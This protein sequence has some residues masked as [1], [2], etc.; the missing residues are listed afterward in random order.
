MEE[1]GNNPKEKAVS[2]SNDLIMIWLHALQLLAQNSEGLK[3]LRKIESSIGKKWL[4]DNEIKLAKKVESYDAA[5]SCG[6]IINGKYRGDEH[7]MIY[8]ITKVGESLNVNL[9][10]YPIYNKAY[11]YTKTKGMKI[12]PFSTAVFITAL[13]EM[14]TRDFRSEMESFNS[15]EETVNLLP[16]EVGLT[17]II[18]LKLSK[19]TIKLSEGDASEL[20]LGLID[21]VSIKHKKSGKRFSGMS[22][23]SSKV[24]KGTVFMSVADARIIGYE[25]GEKA[26]VEKAGKETEKPELVE[27]GEY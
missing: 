1:S 21:D 6:D 7:N 15:E 11:T 3:K 4:Q 9:R 13:K 20:G 22:Y 19:G 12:F 26:V 23:S 5:V 17:I 14:T 16:L 25:E 18:S 24:S 2:Q 8:A 27:I 10:T